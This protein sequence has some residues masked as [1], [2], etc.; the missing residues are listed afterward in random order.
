[1]TLGELANVGEAVGGIA[2]LI[3]LVYLALQIRQNTRTM[4]ATAHHSANQLGVEINLAM[5]TSP[6]VARVLLA[7]SSKEADLEPHQRLMFHLL[8]RATFSGAEDFYIQAREGLLESDMWESRRKS[9][10]VYL[11]QPGV[12][13]WWDQNRGIFSDDFAAALSKGL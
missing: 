8:M 5:G 6:E 11:R 9:M 3:T 4:R 1:M 10:Q 7:S 2:V 13:R 12:K